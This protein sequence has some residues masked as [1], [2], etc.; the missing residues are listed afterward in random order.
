MSFF[1]LVVEGVVGGRGGNVDDADL[2]GVDRAAEVD[3]G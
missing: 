3:E 1:F 2:L